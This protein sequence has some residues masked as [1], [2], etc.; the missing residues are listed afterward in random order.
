MFFIMFS[1]M[2]NKLKFDVIE[3][4]FLV[5]GHSQNENDIAH[6]VIEKHIRDM[7]IYTPAQWEVG[8]TQ[9]FQRNKCIMTVLTHKDIINYKNS[10]S[11]HIVKC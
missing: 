11:H 5:P 4:T 7:T 3:F 2:L 9:A 1:D 6:S 8:S 10:F